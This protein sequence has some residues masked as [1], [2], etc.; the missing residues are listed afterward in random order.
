MSEFTVKQARML[1]G[2]SQKEVGKA[3]G[4]HRQT[5]MTLEADPG[6]FT[7]KQAHDFAEFVGLDYDRIK[8]FC[9]QD[10]QVV[11]SNS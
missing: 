5:Y 6:R 2:R 11:E 3:I 7:I 4:V 10:K 8:F 9:K 1:A